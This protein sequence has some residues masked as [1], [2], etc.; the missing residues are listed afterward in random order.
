MI[1]SGG[2]RKF[3]IET[4][5]VDVVRLD[6]VPLAHAVAEGEGYTSVAEWRAG[7]VQFW[8]SDEMREELGADFELGDDSLVVLERFRIVR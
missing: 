2:Q 3:V 6:A 7:H 5:G 1:D 4:T 8:L